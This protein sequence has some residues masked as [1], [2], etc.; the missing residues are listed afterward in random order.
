MHS[1]FLFSFEE[2]FI[3]L[4]GKINLNEKAAHP[5]WIPFVLNLDSLY[6]RKLHSKKL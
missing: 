1:S 5:G 4:R 6:K 3:S 2:K